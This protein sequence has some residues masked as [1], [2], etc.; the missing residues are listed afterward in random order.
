MGH[1]F[2]HLFFLTKGAI[3]SFAR[4][5]LEE[6]AMSGFD[7]DFIRTIDEDDNVQIAEELSEEEIVVNNKK[8]KG[9]KKAAKKTSQKE[10]MDN[11]FSFSIEGGGN[12][13]QNNMD[14]DFSTTREKLKAQVRIKN[15][16]YHTIRC[17]LTPTIRR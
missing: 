17:M 4:G 11:S 13:K 7:D 9:S 16:A 15:I 10:D 5:P 6:I 1:F 3:P 14:W 8:R 2:L 12:Y